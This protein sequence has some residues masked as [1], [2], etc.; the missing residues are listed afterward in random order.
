MKLSLDKDLVKTVGI[1]AVALGGLLYVSKTEKGKVL[2]SA[3]R[4][5]IDFSGTLNKLKTLFS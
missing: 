1:T 2:V 5:A 4:D 3:F